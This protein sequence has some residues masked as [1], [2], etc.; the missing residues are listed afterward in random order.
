[1]IIYMVF[2]KLLTTCLGLVR[3]FESN[4]HFLFTVMSQMQV[5][6]ITFQFSHDGA[7][8]KSCLSQDFEKHE[9]YCYICEKF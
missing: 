6:Y 4:N 2:Q 5:S 8:F 1:M 7:R 9:N 3:D